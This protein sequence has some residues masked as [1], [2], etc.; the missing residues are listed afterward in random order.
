M[1][2]VR[3]VLAN[4]WSEAVGLGGTALVA[5][6]L[7]LAAP[8][9]S[10]T[11]LTV[12]GAVAVVAAGAGLEGALVGYAQAR[13]L[14]HRLPG[15]R[16]RAWIAATAQG[17]GAAWALGMI[18]STLMALMADPGARG[19]ESPAMFEGASQYFMAAAMGLVLGPILGAPQWW[20]LR[21]HVRRAGWWV[22]ANAAAWAVGMPL[23][24]LGAGAAFEA[25]MPLLAVAFAVGSLALAGLAVG[26]I[27]GLVLVALLR[28]D[29]PPTGR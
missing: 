2:Y 25:S 7:A 5:G 19:G 6:T 23:V 26:A 12:L 10:S 11:L 16:R 28:D 17:A 1:L 27:H 8:D 15:L 20:E 9:P 18:P 4:G 29:R 21:R 3:W 13:V 22:P 14:E 24:F